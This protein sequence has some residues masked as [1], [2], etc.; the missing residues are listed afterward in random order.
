MQCFIQVFDTD[1]NPQ[2]RGGSNFKEHIDWLPML[3]WNPSWSRSSANGS[4]WPRL[5]TVGSM[6][7]TVRGDNPVVPTLQN[8][9]AGQY[10]ADDWS[11]AMIDCFS[12]GNDPTWT[13]R[14]TLQEPVVNGISPN[15]NV[16]FGSELLW[17]VGMN[18]SSSSVDF[19]DPQMKV[20]QFMPSGAIWDP[21]EQVCREFD[22]NDA[23]SRLPE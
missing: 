15:P 3:A 14:V 5:S 21:N 2:L 7:F 20:T 6:L 12:K 23:V 8:V 13:L 19:R 1:G 10:L 22:P 16:G 18:F 9:A 11:K 4:Q 17:D